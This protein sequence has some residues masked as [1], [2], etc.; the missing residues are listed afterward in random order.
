MNLLLLFGLGK[1][2][3]EIKDSHV[4]WNIRNFLGVSVSWNKESF[5][6]W[7]IN[8]FF[9]VSVSRNIRQAFFYWILISWNIRNFLRLDFF[10]IFFYFFCFLGLKVLGS[11][12]KNIRKA[13]FWENIRNFLSL[14]LENS[15]SW[16]IRNF[17]GRMFII[18]LSL[19]WKVH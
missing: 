18:F 2:L 4:S 6:S 17:S 3:P 5:V 15:I 9:A 10:S 13:G 11:I 12:S 7:N 16:N 1:L 8:N 14:E 19:G